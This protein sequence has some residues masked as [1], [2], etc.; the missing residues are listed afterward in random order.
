MFMLV[1]KRDKVKERRKLL[2][3]VLPELDL[4]PLAAQ[5]SVSPTR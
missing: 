1:W 5:L 4:A 3:E 2:L